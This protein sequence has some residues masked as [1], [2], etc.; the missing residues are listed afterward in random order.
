M[1]TVIGLSNYF[2]STKDGRG[3]VFFTAHMAYPERSAKALIEAAY[4]G[5]PR[6]ESKYFFGNEFDKPPY[7]IFKR[8]GL[9]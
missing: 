2:I 4:L 9:E 7:G 8:E 5:N 6:I 1:P 3:I